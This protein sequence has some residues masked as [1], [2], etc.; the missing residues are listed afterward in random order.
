MG[1]LFLCIDWD[2]CLTA[3]HSRI[4]HVFRASSLTRF[5]H[6]AVHYYSLIYHY[7]LL[8][9]IYPCRVLAFW[10]DTIRASH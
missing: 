5:T 1:S 6:S 4:C 8:Y 9:Y 10:L 3:S 2:S 7:T